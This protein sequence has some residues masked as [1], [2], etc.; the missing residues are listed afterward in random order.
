MSA[1]RRLPADVASRIAAGEV[2]EGP[3]S[4]LKELIENSIDAGASKI[5]IRIEKSGKS[6][7]RVSDD[8]AGMSPED[9]RLA[10]E[11][12][13]TSKIEK[14]SDLQS[15]GTFGFRGEALFAIGAVSRLRLSS[16]PR[17][18]KKGW[19]VEIDGGKIVRDREAAP[20]PGTVV[21]VHDL[22]YNTPARRKFLKSDAYERGKLLRVVED[23]ALSHPEASFVVQVGKTSPLRLPGAKSRSGDEGKKRVQT[24]LGEDAG[25]ELLEVVKKTPAMTLRAYVSPSHQLL[26]S[27]GLQRF[28]I[29]G[30]PVESAVLRQALY[31]SYED[32]LPKGRH[33]V[34]VLYLDV[35]GDSVDVNVHPQKREVRFRSDPEIFEFIQSA[36]QAQVLGQK[37]APALAFGSYPPAG[38]PA[39]APLELPEREPATLFPGKK[40]PERFYGRIFEKAKK[41]DER[42][43]EVRA[44]YRPARPVQ[45]TILPE[46]RAEWPTWYAPPLRYLGQVERAYLIF[47]AQGGL[48]LLDQHAAAERVLFERFLSDLKVG[49]PPVQKLMMPHSIELPPSRLERMLEWKVFLQDTGFDIEASGRGSLLVHSVPTLFELDQVEMEE[50][51]NRL[52]DEIGD[53][54]K[55]KDEVKNHA[56]ATRACKCAIKAHDPLSEREAMSLV[57][58]LKNCKD[59][60]ACPHGRP[61]VLSLTRDELARKFKRPGAVPI[62]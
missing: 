39:P 43:A 23:A 25:R 19:T 20:A 46:R 24:V 37:T 10:T 54:R 5:Q 26:A 29:N 22:F 59:S 51:L 41:K 6:L 15:L 30:R 7:I 56:I 8:G 21:E 2:V 50:F 27:R 35:P 61:A 60:F 49:H 11:R 42:V 16:T 36:L 14:L 13:A 48:L 45:T 4:V 18:A 53:P 32:Y 55:V 28:F 17:R 34:G 44:P 12:H 47:E 31:K 57:E 58:D 62:L 52:L 3:G 9:L 40:V 33:P 38:A 1:V